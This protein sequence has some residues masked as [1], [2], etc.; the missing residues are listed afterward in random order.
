MKIAI[1][2]DHGG[3]EYKASIIKALQVKGYDVVDMGTYSPESCDYPIIAKKVARAV[4]KGDFEK[5]ILVCGTGIG[6][7]MAANKVKGIRAAVCGDTFSARATRAHNNANILCLGQRVVGE[8]LALD[9][10]D[11]WLTTKFEGGR[12]ERRVNMIEE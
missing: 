12:H 11:I 10:V 1:G 9:I 7:S 8:G 5:G 2:S 4:A 6:M 3:F